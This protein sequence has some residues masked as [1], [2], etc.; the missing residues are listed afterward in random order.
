MGGRGRVAGKP[1]PAELTRGL[2]ALY[3]IAFVVEMGFAALHKMNQDF[4]D[5]A[6]SCAA[7]L[8]QML[9]QWW[10][11]PVAE[12]AGFLDPP[13]VVALEGGTA[14]LAVVYWPL[15]LLL[16]LGFLFGLAVVGPTGFTAVSIA[17]AFS[18]VRGTTAES[19]YRVPR[20]WPIA[21]AASSVALV[22]YMARTYAGPP[23]YPWGQ[24]AFYAVVVAFLAVCV[25]SE[26]VRDLR[27][28]RLGG[29]RSAV[30]LDGPRSRGVRILLVAVAVIG[31]VDGLTPYFGYKYHFSFSMLSNL[32]AD[33]VRWNSYV[34]PQWLR[35]V[36]EDPFIEV[37]ALEIHR[38]GGQ[39]TDPDRELLLASFPPYEFRRRVYYHL[40]HG[41]DVDVW[42]RYQGRE[43]GLTRLSRNPEGRAFLE[44]LPRTL[45]FQ[46]VLLPGPQSC[47]H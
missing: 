9:P 8:N 1:D 12:L 28:R 36:D 46:K 17:A 34:V 38:E 22:A 29:F 39:P 4:F 18:F 15:G 30:G 5:P 45:L 7:V 27:G 24:F 2:L 13:V 33:G 21:F 32:R 40:V 47:V 41:Q 6:L 31:V 35:L 37:T 3:R 10:D 23:E 11:T 42:I 43:H 14:L 44:A 16:T 20:R 25:A 19:F 26:L